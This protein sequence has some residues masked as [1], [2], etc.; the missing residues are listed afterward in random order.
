MKQK[1]NLETKQKGNALDFAARSIDLTVQ[2]VLLS[3]KLRKDPSLWPILDQLIRSTGSI[4]AN[5]R[6]AHGA[7]TKKDF[8]NFFSIAFKSSNETLYWLEVLARCTSSDV[9]K[10][11]RLA[12]ETQHLRNILCASVRTLRTASS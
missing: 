3:R 4:G 2:V 10:V 6:E 12:G 8:A 7:P 5:V 11:Q 1:M 9:E